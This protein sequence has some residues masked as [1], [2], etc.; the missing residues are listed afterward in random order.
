VFGFHALW[1]LFVLLG[2]IC[3]FV[4]VLKHIALA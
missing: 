1:H 3:H 4:M 2:S